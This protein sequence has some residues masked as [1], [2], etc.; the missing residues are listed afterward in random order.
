MRA[1]NMTTMSLL[2][3]YHATCMDEGGVPYSNPEYY[4]LNILLGS[5]GRGEAETVSASTVRAAA[6]ADEGASA[7]LT[8]SY[9]LG[10]LGRGEAQTV[11]TN[12]VCTA[13]GADERAVL[14]G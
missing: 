7:W 9:L 1:R 6:G 8:L 13:A 11:S 5:L 3:A 4:M 14:R 2:P 12:T 10:S